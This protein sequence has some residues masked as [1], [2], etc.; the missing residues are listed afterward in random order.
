VL[1]N[2]PDPLVS[3]AGTSTSVLK[4][5]SAKRIDHDAALSEDDAQPQPE[6]T[7]KKDELDITKI[8]AKHLQEKSAQRSAVE[9]VIYCWLFI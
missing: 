6:K 7:S 9:I 5:K 8:R 4:S 3:I 2:T 1:D